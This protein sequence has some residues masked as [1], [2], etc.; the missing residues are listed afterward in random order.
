MDN[1][2]EILKKAF[3]EVLKHPEDVD[4]C[5]FCKHKI[6][7]RGKNCP[8]YCSGVG[9]AEGKYPNF[10]WTCEDFNFGTCEIMENSPCKECIFNDYSGF[11]LDFHRLNKDDIHEHE[12]TYEED[13][14]LPTNNEFVN[15][16]IFIK[17]NCKLTWDELR[18]EL[19]NRYGFV[20][21]EN[22]T[23]GVSEQNGV[24]IYSVK[25]QRC[26]WKEM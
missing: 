18:A 15:V 11:E 26:S 21:L 19:Y 8:K 22:S 17:C 1:Q 4:P 9:D 14:F 10:K 12:I 24:T 5:N 13:D 16:D 7:C 25:I 2:F 20:L 3:I 23:Y 6:K